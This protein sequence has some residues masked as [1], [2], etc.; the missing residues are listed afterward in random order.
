MV[1]EKKKLIDEFMKNQRLTAKELLV[2]HVQYVRLYSQHH[3]TKRFAVANDFK[4]SKRF[5][6][7]LRGC[8]NECECKCYRTILCVYVCMYVCMCVLG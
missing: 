5:C 7:F 3:C 2:K 6:N 1:Q 8:E 4:F